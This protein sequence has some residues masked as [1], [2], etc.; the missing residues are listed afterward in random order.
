VKFE[1]AQEE[2]QKALDLVSGVVPSKTTLPILKS[3]LVEA[4]KD[5]LQ[6]SVTNLDISMVTTTSEVKVATE[7]RAAVPADKFTSF[8]RSLAPGVV[9]VAMTGGKLSVKSGKASLSEQ[10]QNAEEYPSLPEL[11]DRA[12]LTIGGDVLSGM[13][14][15]TAYAVF[16]DET[17]PA[18]M[19][20]LW[21]VA[22]DGLTMVATDAHRLARSQRTLDWACDETRSMIVDTTGLRHLP[23]I[24]ARTD[25]DEQV[26]V[27][28]GENQL[29][30]RA[31]GSVLHMRLLEGPFPDYNAVIPKDN[32]KIVTVDREALAQAIR[33]VSITADRVTS[34]IRLGLESERLELTAKGQDG[35]RAEDEIAVGYDG[36]AM[37]IGFNY[38]YLLD[39]LK[40]VR[41]DNV[42]FALRDAQSAALIAP[43]DDEGKSDPGLLCL[44]MPL[45]LASD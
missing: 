29:S 19:G 39:I 33:R 17:R 43:A 41:T 40:N 30:F 7:G 23:R 27:F 1:I 10:C 21:E 4:G 44:L 37:E 42:Q 35:S 18:L 45:R 36:E 20:I 12:P 28:L 8:V 15:E 5:G 26:E 16:R 6:F 24:A 25:E 34:Q 14:A 22:P 31:G 2:L 32:D 9:Q 38:S 11:T 13:I 3:I